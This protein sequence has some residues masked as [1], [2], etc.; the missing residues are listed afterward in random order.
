MKPIA[1]MLCFLVAAL[2][3][4]TSDPGY[5]GRSSDQWMEVLRAGDTRNKV[6]AANALRK[7]LE[8]EPNYPKVV[9]A[10][11]KALRDTSDEVR[12]AAA[13]AL[14]AEGVDP[15]V[16]VAGLHAV[17]HDS[18]HADVR[19]SIVLIIGNLD[20]KRAELLMPSLREA[21]GDP[22]ASVRATA[23]QAIGV[24]GSSKSEIAVVV[25]LARDES[26]NVRQ[27]VLS[28][29]TDLHA[30]ASVVLPIA[31]DGLA[32]ND[33]SVRMAAASALAALGPRASIAVPELV[34]AL[35]DKDRAVVA[36]VIQAIAA[37]GPKAKAAIPELTRLSRTEPANLA[38]SA[39]NA[40]AVVQGRRSNRGF[41]EPTQ[42]EKCLGISSDPRC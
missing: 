29:L 3:G 35:K 10:L 13:S 42:Q 12:I 14:S 17:L 7:V 32:D 26:P 36:N 41:T 21:I 8:I 11:A 40:L 16:A 6:D 38:R 5:A 9:N 20:R 22:D 4:C 1:V 31:C 25:G 19:R 39:E 28:S 27:A 18:A 34:Q 33:P 2:V 24:I 15:S 23:V 30:D 37:I